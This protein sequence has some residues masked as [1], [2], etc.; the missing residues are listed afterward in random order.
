M[1]KTMYYSILKYSGLL[2]L[3]R[4][5]RKIAGRGRACILLYHRV[6][7]LSD[8]PLTTSVLRFA[9]Q[10]L[11]LRKYYAVVPSSVLVERLETGQPFPSNMVVIHF[12]D[13]YRDVFMHAR[14][15]LEG[16]GFP[17]SVFVSSGYVGTG[18][19]FPHDGSSPWAFENLRR[20][21]L[22][23]LAASSFEVGSHTV[24]HVDLAR[25]TDEAVT[26]E[27]AQSKRDLEAIMGRPVTLFSF[28]FGGEENVHPGIIERVRQVGYRAMFSAHGGYVRPGSD[29]FDLP[30]VGISDT[31]RP[32]DLLMEI[33]GLSLAALRRRFSRRRRNPRE[34][35]RAS[36]PAE[37]IAVK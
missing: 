27:L 37:R 35:I 29:L 33:E 16:L 4:V 28:P 6:N 32:L 36:A 30:R 11:A 22:R 21:E 19:R 9:E 7:D 8:D 10:M 18:R 23:E 5:A 24:N 25:C 1:A 20:E 15:V 14:P 2:H 12:D 3:V 31:T 13:C 17:A 26:A 34:Y